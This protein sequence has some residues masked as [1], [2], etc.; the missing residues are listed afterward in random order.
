MTVAV[1]PLIRTNLVSPWLLGALVAWL[2]LAAAPSQAEPLQPARDDEVVETLPGG[3]RARSEER[4]LRQ[5][6]AARPGDPVVAVALARSYLDQAR[7]EGD[8]RFAGRALAVLQHWPQPAAAPPEVVLMSATLQQYLHDFDGS[9]RLLEGLV[10]REPRHAQAW[11]TLATI[12]RVQGRYAPSDAACRSLAATG[13]SFYGQ[14]CEAENA[15]LKGQFDAA[16]AQLAA[17]L[18]TPGL[19]ASSRAW[20]LTTLAEL[21]T[22]AGRRGQA[23][24]A[25]RSVLAA[26]PD[27]YA[28]LS[29]ADFLL[30]QQRPAEVLVLLKGQPRSD[31]LLLRLAMAGSLLPSASAQADIAELRARMAQAALRPSSQ[32][33]HARE[34]A[35][36]AWKVDG[37]PARALEL[38]LKNVDLQREPI[39]VLL[40]ARTAKAAERADV[41]AQARQISQAMGLKDERLDALF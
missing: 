14:A 16:R 35:L 36:F 7:A 19:P 9:A 41:L 22:R 27:E 12:R 3:S 17:L 24:A 25:Y 6:W 37:Q 23:E 4:A 32:T 18:A 26:Q 11:L 2:A 30:D 28:R 20:L 8:P 31:A 29:F 1:S 13:A 39:D 5:R 40:L 34:Q 33:T 10:Q 21:E 15:S 38:A